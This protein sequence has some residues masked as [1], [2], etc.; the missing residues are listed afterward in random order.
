MYRAARPCADS[1]SAP[2]PPPPAALAFLH[3]VLSFAVPLLDASSGGDDD[4]DDDEEEVSGA[5]SHEVAA[6][7]RGLCIDFLHAYFRSERAREPS[8]MELAT[9]FG[10]LLGLPY[11]EGVRI[12]HPEWK[13]DPS[14]ELD[15]G[16]RWFIL[17]SELHMLLEFQD[18][19]NSEGGKR[20]P[21]EWVPTHPFLGPVYRR[22]SCRTCGLLPGAVRDKPFQACSLCLDP[23]VGRFCCKE[24]CFAAF[25][26][27][28]H[29]KEC[30]G[31]DKWKKKMGE[32]K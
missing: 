9:C 13:L 18:D 19:S 16:K 12:F 28:G 5:L 11:S 3:N 21:Q 6:A 14:K 10:T 15:A 29:K 7:R 22:Y 17:P 2:A 25:W 31:R 23:A 32:G 4:D 30:A 27:G 8:D 20:R 1:A 26:K 24:P